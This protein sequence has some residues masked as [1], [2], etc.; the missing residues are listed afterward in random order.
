MKQA[1]LLN[2]DQ[3]LVM[4]IMCSYQQVNNYDCSLYAIKNVQ[5]VIN[6]WNQSEV[7]KNTPQINAF[8]HLYDTVIKN[9]D[10]TEEEV[11]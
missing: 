2:K 11:A 3:S 8:N 6:Y 7:M 10:W 9:W 1:E 5:A 4:K